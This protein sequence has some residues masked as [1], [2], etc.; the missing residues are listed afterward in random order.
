MRG[1]ADR[2]DRTDRDLPR[3]HRGNLHRHLR[4][5]DAHHRRRHCQRQ[6]IAGRQRGDDNPER[7]VLQWNDGGI[8]EPPDQ[9]RR[10]HRD[11]GTR[12]SRVFRH[13]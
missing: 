9:R 12:A 6:A 5:R 10:R 3:R 2:S 11:P 4:Q 7:P 8:P 13:P 1:A